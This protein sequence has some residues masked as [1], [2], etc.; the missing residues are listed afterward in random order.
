[1]SL[2]THRC[3]DCGHPDYW[4]LTRMGENKAN[5]PADGCTCRC[6]PGAPQVVPT[7]DL[8]GRPVERVIKPGQPL[9]T[10]VPTHN[11]DACKAL[12]DELTGEAA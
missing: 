12:Y 7:F 6:V 1:M 5:C 2:I 11:C 4:R 8:A 3:T 10:G 9:Y